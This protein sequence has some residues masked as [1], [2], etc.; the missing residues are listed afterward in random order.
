MIGTL[1]K[2]LLFVGR[3]FNAA[4]NVYLA[5]QLGWWAYKEVRSAQKEKFRADQ[6]RDRFVTEY[7][8]E[9][10]KE[11]DEKDVALALRSYNA[12][13]HP[14]QERVKNLLGLGGK[15]EVKK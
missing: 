14:Y 9:Y 1:L 5:G 13:E 3:S 4:A 6:L 2:P 7:V 11:P 15:G 12:V 8:D 10:G